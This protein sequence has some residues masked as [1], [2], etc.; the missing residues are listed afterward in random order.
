MKIFLILVVIGLMWYGFR[1]LLED[2][3]WQEA[4]REALEEID[5]LEKEGR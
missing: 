4:K 5:R 1:G 3:R 2:M